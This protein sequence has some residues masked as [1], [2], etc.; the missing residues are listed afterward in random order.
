MGKNQQQTG[1]RKLDGYAEWHM[2]ITS[3]VYSLLDFTGVKPVRLIP[4]EETVM[5]VN[6]N[7]TCIYDDELG[8]DVVKPVDHIPVMP[9]LTEE[10]QAVLKKALPEIIGLT[11]VTSL[12][13]VHPTVALAADAGQRLLSKE[14]TIIHTLQM[15]AT[16]AAIAI[17]IWGL[18]EWAVLN[19]PH[20]KK[21]I[22]ESLWLLIG[23]KFIPDLWMTIAA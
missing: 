9:E 14:Q 5:R 3:V 11:T 18:I 13:A 22:W 4:K 15:I 19:N 8:I 16:P 23:I 2:R 1:D 21:K 6:I 10:Q 20:G 17:A 12:L 7:G